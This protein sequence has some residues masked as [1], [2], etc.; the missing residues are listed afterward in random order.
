ML[1]QHTTL[2]KYRPIWK[3]FIIQPADIADMNNNG[4]DVIY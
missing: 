2:L 4:T 3:I 1:S